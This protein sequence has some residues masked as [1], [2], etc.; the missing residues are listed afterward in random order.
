MDVQR[1]A[2]VAAQACD[3]RRWSGSSA[4][5]ARRQHVFVE[6]RSA[7]G[8]PR[9][10]ASKWESGSLSQALP[11]AAASH[12]LVGLTHEYWMP[13]SDILCCLRCRP[14]VR[15]LKKV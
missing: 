15:C 9:N 13:F 5:L 7:A 8:Q 12:R 11:G 1:A 14:A 2:A 3:T 6:K 4:G 10:A